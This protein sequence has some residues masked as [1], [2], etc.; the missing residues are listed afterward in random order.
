MRCSLVVMR[1]A[2]ALYRLRSSVYFV[3]HTCYRFR[4]RISAPELVSLCYTHARMPGERASVLRSSNVFHVA[5]TTTFGALVRRYRELRDLK[6]ED[7]AAMAGVRQGTVSSV[8]NETQEPTF[9]TVA[10]IAEALSI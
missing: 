8:E 10:R 9:E 7:V 3:A 6:Q 5:Q 1:M 4:Y 2:Y